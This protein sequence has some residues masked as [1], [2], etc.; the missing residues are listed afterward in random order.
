MPATQFDR[1]ATAQWYA[2]QHLNT[3]P[4]IRAVYYLPTNAPDREI[5]FVEVNELV[6]DRNDD[7]L[8]PVDF[9][10]D[11]GTESEHKLF[12]LDVTPSQWDRINQSS[13]SLPPGWSLDAAVPF[14]QE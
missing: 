4:G 12:V 7:T 5:R 2:T 13:L 10:V 14:D 8:E 3:D 1:N 11:T 9:G 6:A